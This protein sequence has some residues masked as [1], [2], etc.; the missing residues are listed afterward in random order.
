[1]RPSAE[2]TEVANLVG[3]GSTTARSPGGRVSRGR[4]FAIG[5]VLGFERPPR[6][7]TSIELVA[8]D[9]DFSLL[10]QSWAHPLRRLPSDPPDKRRRQAI[11][12]SALHVHQ[13]L[14]RHPPDLLP[15][16]RRPRHRLA[17]DDVEAHPDCPPRRRRKARR[18]RRP[19]GLTRA[20]TAYPTTASS[21]S[22]IAAGATS[23]PP[24]RPPRG[25]S[26]RTSSPARAQISIPAAA[27]HGFRPRS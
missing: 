10:P 14:R 9:H 23:T 4:P 17:A 16:P 2:L 21:S 22:A 3:R 20:A 25:A 19:E 6:R 1:V 15:L 12:P 7:R 11:C 27:S 5:D 8:H 18:L 26:V 13:P 24:G